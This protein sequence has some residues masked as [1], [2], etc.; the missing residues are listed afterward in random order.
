MSR[1]RDLSVPFGQLT[2]DEQAEVLEGAAKLR[3]ELTNWSA[4]GDEIRA[5][6]GKRQLVTVQADVVRSQL[7]ESPPAPAKPSDP[8]KK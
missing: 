1:A 6:N 5:V 7:P 4:V 8:V 2:E 3:P